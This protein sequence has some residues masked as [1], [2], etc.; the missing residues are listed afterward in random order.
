MLT[1][2][3]T[4]CFGLILLLLSSCS[5]QTSFSQMRPGHSLLSDHVKKQIRKIEKSIIGVVA[6]IEYEIQRFDYELNDDRLI[7]DAASPVGYRLSVTRSSDG[8]LRHNEEIAFS[9]GGIIVNKNPGIDRYVILTSSHLVSVRDTVD[10]FYLDKNG[11]PTDMVFQRRIVRKN[12]LTVRG[13]GNWRVAAELLAKNPIDDIALITVKAER[14]LGYTYNNQMDYDLD[15]SWGDWVFLFGYPKEIKQMTGGWVSQSPYRGTF[16]VD[17]VV[18]FGF[19]GSPVFAFS[20]NR[21]ELILAGIVKSVPS[22][23]FEYIAP[24]GSLPVGYAL[25]QSDLEKMAVKREMVVNYGTVYCVN[26]QRIRSFF[27]ANEKFMNR[28]GIWLAPMYFGEQEP[29]S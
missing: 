20:K 19:S 23:S 22:S 15:L 7:P 13:P 2:K 16:S 6:N 4:L 27:R 26:S 25:R 17:A 1:R 14:S 24:D 21:Q 8:I 29:D 18:R 11:K 28:K 12:Q 5:R 9:G 3:C 10:T